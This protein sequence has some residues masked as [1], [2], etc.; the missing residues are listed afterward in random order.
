ME[1]TT[2]TRSPAISNLGIAEVEDGDNGMDL[3]IRIIY[4]IVGIALVASSILFVMYIVTRL[5]KKRET[6]VKDH[7]HFWSHKET[8]TGNFS[9]TDFI[10]PS[11]YIAKKATDFNE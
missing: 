6:A 5:L 9:K 4:G 10:N 8:S 3:E 11:C 1:V 2:T 7:E